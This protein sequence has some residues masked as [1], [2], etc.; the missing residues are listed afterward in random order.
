[1]SLCVHS[2]SIPLSGNETLCCIQLY[3]VVCISIHPLPYLKEETAAYK[4][5]I[6]YSLCESVALFPGHFHCLHMHFIMVEFHQHHGP[7]IYVRTPVMSNGT[8]CY[9]VCI[10]L[11]WWVQHQYR[12]IG[13]G[14][15]SWCLLYRVFAESLH[16]VESVKR[17]VLHVYL[18]TL[19]VYLNR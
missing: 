12:S 6:C 5:I 11:Q 16:H 17:Q 18:C 15:M 13:S 8:Q 2:H 4:A 9:M 14:H 10:H 1:M 19:Y 3:K 7:S